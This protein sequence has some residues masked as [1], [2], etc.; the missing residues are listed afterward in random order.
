MRL[1]SS[2]ALV[3][4]EAS[5]SAPIGPIAWKLLYAAGVA[6]KRK[7]KKKSADEF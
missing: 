4:A 7:E 6:V 5:A 3:V 1:G 2:V